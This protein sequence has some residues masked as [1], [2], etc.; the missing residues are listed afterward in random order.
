LDAAVDHHS[1]VA[2]RSLVGRLCLM[3]FL[4]YAVRG[5]WYPFLA[6]YLSAPRD[7]GG[8]GFSPGQVGWVLGFANAVGAVTAPFIAGQVADRFFNAER[9]L[10]VFHVVAAALL[11]LNASSTSFGLFFL[12]MLLFSVAYVPTQ[13]LTNSLALTHL[14]DRERSYPR[15]RMFG[16]IGW[17]VTSSLFTYV[18]M[19]SGDR[20][21]DIAR[22]P[23]ALRAA[24]VMAIGYAGYAFFLLPAT[25]P[26]NNGKAGDRKRG[27]DPHPG[28]LPGYRERE[29]GASAARRAFRLLREPSVLVLSVTAV[30]IACIHTAYYLNI[31]PFLT[32][33]VGVRER[34]LGPTIAVSQTSEV[35]FLFL[36]G[37]MLKRFGYKAMLVVG[38]AAQA[39]R[40]AIFAVDPG[41]GI[42]IASLALHGVAFA[43]FQTTAVLYIERV[44]PED[45]RHSAQTVFGIVLFGIGPALA[46]PYSQFFDRF[47]VDGRPDY[48]AIWWVQA[49]VAMVAVAGVLVGFRGKGE[50]K[51]VVG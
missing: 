14:R 41:A 46:G 3:M 13:S 28:P 33:A 4:E 15:T 39:L 21:T 48:R 31:G 50:E 27:E 45:I 19:R 26:A 18:V 30:L 37:P 36:L 16:T 42:V 38:A 10:A 22:I 29:E 5:M 8:L 32:A 9:A 43:C 51:G 47:V 2:R 1:A 24:A 6:N 11:F 49:G 25:P 35:A 20:A 23:M 44:A 34:M 12:Y 7:V 40:F 17:V